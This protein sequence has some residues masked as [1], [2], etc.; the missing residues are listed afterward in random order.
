MAINRDNCVS[1]LAVCTGSVPDELS[2]HPIASLQQKYSSIFLTFGLYCCNTINSFNSINFCGPRRRLD[3]RRERVGGLFAR[4]ELRVHREWDGDDGG[5]SPNRHA[6]VMVGEPVRSWWTPKPE[7][8][9]ILESIFNS[10]MVNTPKDE[11]VHIRKLLKLFSAVGDANVFYWFQ[12][13]RS[14]SRRR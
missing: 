13:H 3:A 6:T 2:S 14:R 4:R 8:I 12:N 7:Q 1:Q 11:T 5:H 10:S 9:L